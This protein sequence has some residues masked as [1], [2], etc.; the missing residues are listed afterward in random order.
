MRTIAELEAAAPPRPAS[1]AL[2][3][4]T[5][6][7]ASPRSAGA[8]RSFGN[9]LENELALRPVPPPSLGSKEGVLA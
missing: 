4:S 6:D 7:A 2:S 1:S 3:S 9:E 8:A 5:T